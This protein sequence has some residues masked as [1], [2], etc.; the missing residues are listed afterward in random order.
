VESWLAAH[1]LVIA[2]S[3][4]FPAMPAVF[5]AFAQFAAPHH[6]HPVRSRTAAKQGKRD[7]FSDSPRLG[8]RRRFDER[9]DVQPGRHLTHQAQ[10]E[11]KRGAVREDRASF[12]SR[13]GAK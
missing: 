3:V 4:A 5:F 1:A 11:R 7:D 13:K 12:V 8:P 6:M 2:K 10:P 9:R